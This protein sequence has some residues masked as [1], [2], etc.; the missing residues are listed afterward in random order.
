MM[1]KILL[2]VLTI[3]VLSCCGIG[4]TTGNDR[5]SGSVMADVTATGI[6]EL[7]VSPK[8]IAATTPTPTLCPTV[9]SALLL[10]VTPMATNIPTVTV[11]Y[12][13]T[14]EPTETSM[15]T[16][17]PEPTTT[18]T[19]T[20]I[21]EMPEF[22]LSEKIPVISVMTENEQP[23][24]SKEEYVNCTVSLYNTEE[25]GLKEQP[26]GIRVR[27]NSSAYGGRKED[28]LTKEVPYRIKFEEKTNLLG[29]NDGAECKSWVILRADEGLVRDEIA[30][31]MGRVLLGEDNYCSD[32]QLVHLYVNGEFKGVFLLCE[33]SQVNK[34][35]VDIYEPEKG[36]THTDIGYLLEIDNY[37]NRN[38][39]P[40]FYMDYEKAQITDIEG[41]TDTFTYAYYS[42]K[43]EIVSKEQEM[44]IS[45]YTKNVFKLVYEACVNQNYL[46]FDEDY[47]LVESEY[48]NAKDT[49]D[50]VLNMDSIVGSYI[51]EELMHDNDCGEGSFFMCIDFSEESRYPKLTF[52]CPWDYDWTCQGNAQ[53]QYYAGTFNDPNFVEK[54][55]DR[56]NPW[57]V[58]LMTQ[59]WFVEL[60]KEKWTR[61]RLDAALEACFQAE[62]NYMEEYKSD[63]NRKKSIATDTGYAILNWLERRVEWL[64]EEWLLQ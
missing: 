58:L 32:S 33:Q 43:S 52:T 35:R 49:V 21:V 64:D 42:I 26:A 44:F 7:S 28:L 24:L 40:C 10:T 31:R 41:V 53:G 51:L 50:A 4:C 61:V 8:L 55:G 3:L 37:A 9:E 39:H 59:D 54:Y 57:F 1:K 20:P 30:F 46:A 6:P 60:V 17:I 18:S 63:L 5:S 27:G 13:P 15:P 23:I 45:T 16:P 25:Y 38:E 2:I 22:S 48:N 19:P 36:E 14:P 62:K 56:S 11:T 34:H 12:V 47:N 29:L